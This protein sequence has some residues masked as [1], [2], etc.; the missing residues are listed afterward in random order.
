MLIR[1]QIQGFR[2]TAHLLREEA[3]IHSPWSLPLCVGFGKR[4][5]PIWRSHLSQG[6]QWSPCLPSWGRWERIAVKSDTSL[7]FIIVCDHV[8]KHPT[9]ALFP[10]LWGG[11]REGQVASFHLKWRRLSLR[12][13]SWLWTHQMY[14]LFWIFLKF[15]PFICVM[16]HTGRRQMPKYEA[17]FTPYTVSLLRLVTQCPL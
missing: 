10:H 6:S 4:K 13:F 1:H 16:S 2:A 9:G 3:D 12:S 11:W 17:A 5:L 8:W 15:N 7:T 14:I